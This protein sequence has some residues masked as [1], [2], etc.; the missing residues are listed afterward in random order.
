MRNNTAPG[1]ALCG[2]CLAVAGPGHADEPSLRQL[3]DSKGL[4]IGAAVMP[5][6]LDDPRF[7][8]LL[9]DTCNYITPENNLKWELV[10]PVPDVYDFSG[11]D[12]IVDFALRNNMRVRGHTLVWHR[13]LPWWLG[14][15]FNNNG[16]WRE[17]LHQHI[18]TVVTHYKGKIRDWDVVN[19]PIDE[20][21]QLRDS[22][23]YVTMG[24]QYI[25]LA[26]TW[27]HQSDPQAQLF[28][29]DYGIETEGI[30]ADALYKLAKD[31]KRRGVPLHGIGMQFHLDGQA[32]APDWGSVLR[33]IQR[34]VALGLKVQF[35]EIDVRL[36][37]PP[38]DDALKRQASIYAEL[39]KIAV[40]SKH[41]YIMW[42]LYDKHSWVPGFFADY[43]AALIFD[44][45]AQP[46]PAYTAI[47][48]V[49][50]SS[51]SA[52]KGN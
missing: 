12:K 26:L 27:A 35:T 9:K 36:L 8:T 51:K 50:R 49:L 45:N 52:P 39:A 47:Y 6:Q 38:S 32:V 21:G 40:S 10:H 44:E 33:N 15:S 2:L 34:F 31:L 3:A 23:W 20:N 5:D 14:V 7:V 37:M 42:G 17:V 4:T 30:K 16:P 11:S 1:I 46:K 25:E 41:D 43:G 28:I 19:E 13:Q 24:P 48:D 18:R 22:P 29:N